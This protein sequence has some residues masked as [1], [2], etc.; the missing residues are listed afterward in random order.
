[1]DITQLNDYQIQG[2]AWMLAQE[3]QLHA[4]ILAD[5]PGLGKTSSLL[6]R[7]ITDRLVQCVA[8]CEI[9]R[10][11]R[12]KEQTLILCPASLVNDPWEDHISAFTKVHYHCRH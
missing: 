3:R 1:M 6:V 11:M 12:P 8:L 5:E 10:L 4:G 9:S 7:A 2:V